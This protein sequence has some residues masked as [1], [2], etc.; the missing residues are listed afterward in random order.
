MMHLHWLLN[1]LFWHCGL[2]SMFY[3]IETSYLDF[4][5][6]LLVFA[7]FQERSFIK[8]SMTV[9]TFR[10]RMSSLILIIV[11]AK[12]GECQHQSTGFFLV[13]IFP[14]SDWI[15]RFVNLR[16]QS[17]FEKI[18]TRKNSVDWRLHSPHLAL[19]IIRPNGKYVST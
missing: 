6:I 3:P 15:R 14:N 9:F 16:I 18:R 17:E 5:Q 13:R 7:T 4:F 19:T 2:H 10:M 11:T 1:W 8:W 12:C